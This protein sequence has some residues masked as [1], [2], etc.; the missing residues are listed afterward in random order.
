[1]VK[2]LWLRWLKRGANVGKSVKDVMKYR[3]LTN[4]RTKKHKGGEPKWDSKREETDAVI[5]RKMIKEG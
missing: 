4:R 5:D 2:R 3:D 1:M